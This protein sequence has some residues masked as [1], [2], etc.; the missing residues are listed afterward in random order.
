ML[1]ILIVTVNLIFGLT[2]ASN[3]TVGFFSLLGLGWLIASDYVETNGDYANYLLAYNTVNTGITPFEKGY[4]QLELLAYNQ[5]L[6][7]VDFRMC[8]SL[9]TM[10]I[11]FCSIVRFTSNVSLFVVLFSTT[12][13]FT[14][15]TQIRN[16]MMIALAILATSF[17]KKISLL[18][19]SIFLILIYVAT[20]IH[21]SG[22]SFF[23]ILLVRILPYKKL[24]KVAIVTFSIILIM[25]VAFKI[26]GFRILFQ[27]LVRIFGSTV[28]RVNFL[29]KL[30]SYTAGTS[31]YTIL[32]LWI[33][34]IATI[35]I[36]FII[37]KLLRELNID[38]VTI[39]AKLLFSGMTMSI[40]AMPLIVMAP[41]YSRISRN[42]TLFLFILVAL[43]SEVTHREKKSRVSCYFN[44]T[45]SKILLSLVFIL[46]PFVFVHNSIWGPVFLKSIP[47]TMRLESPYIYHE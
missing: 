20:Q 32:L 5:G 10:I 23:A 13:F 3:R 24:K 40:I 41:D 36:A 8:F 15:G 39:K 44:K 16:L 27:L 45:K 21:S 17:L 1:Y 34:I 47:Y 30:Q 26:F 9:I 38:K 29:T 42:A 18:N 46:V 7:Y 37:Y 19:V 12:T 2:T 35:A 22:Y 11:L 4:T 6:T 43:Y 31:S 28:Q 25:S 33:T 14:D